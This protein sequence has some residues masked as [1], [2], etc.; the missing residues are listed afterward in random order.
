VF[1]IVAVQGLL[2]SQALA[3]HSPPYH[4]QRL[5]LIALAEMGLVHAFS[6]FDF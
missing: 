1:D 6:E 4:G 5:C 3:S 2:A